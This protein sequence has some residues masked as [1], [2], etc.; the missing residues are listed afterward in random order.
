MNS[1]GFQTICSMPVP[2]HPCLSLQD[3]KYGAKLGCFFVCWTKPKP[4]LSKS[5]G[6]LHPEKASEVVKSNNSLS[7]FTDC[8]PIPKALEGPYLPS[9]V[10]ELPAKASFPVPQPNTPTCESQALLHRLCSSG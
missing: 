1:H 6:S 7:R 8:P 2:H 3:W 5:E 4:K 10:C 9:P